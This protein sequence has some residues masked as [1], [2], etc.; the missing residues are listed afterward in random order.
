LRLLAI[1][2]RANQLCNGSRLVTR[3]L[4]GMDF[5]GR[6]GR[7][8][9]NSSPVS[10]SSSPRLITNSAIAEHMGDIAQIRNDAF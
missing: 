6:A 4:P 9:T 7:C 2:G 3:G 10:G 1:I 5:S 8:G